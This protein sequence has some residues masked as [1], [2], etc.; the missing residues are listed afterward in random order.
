M[1]KNV[2]FVEEGNL[3]TRNTPKK[4]SMENSRTNYWKA[5]CSE[6]EASHTVY[7]MR[8]GK[9]SWDSSFTGKITK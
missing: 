2:K 7:L 8:V 9:M 6:N 3:I 5:M 4:A 1:A